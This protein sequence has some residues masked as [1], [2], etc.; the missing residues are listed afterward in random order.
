MAPRLLASALKHGLE[1]LLGCL[2]SG[3]A[4]PFVIAV[5]PGPTGVIEVTTSLSKPI[6]APARHAGSA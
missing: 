3:E 2:M 1:R 6:L 5:L 4:R